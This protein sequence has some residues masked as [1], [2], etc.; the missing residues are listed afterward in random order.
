MGEEILCEKQ[1]ALAHNHMIAEV[2]SCHTCYFIEY[3]PL[4]RP[5]HCWPQGG[6]VAQMH[7]NG[8]PIKGHE[9]NLRCLNQ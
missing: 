9:E 8:S 1:Y 2:R 5:Y 6:A 4:Q 3:L 7:E